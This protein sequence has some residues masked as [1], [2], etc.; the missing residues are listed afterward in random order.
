MK[1]KLLLWTGLTTSILFYTLAVFFQ[2]EIFEGFCELMALFE[3]YELDEIVLPLMI[4][5]FF[6]IIYLVQIRK[7]NEI[8]SKKSKIHLDRLKELASSKEILGA[9]LT[10]MSQLKA[11]AIQNSNLDPD[12]MLQFDKRFE[13]VEASTH[14]LALLQ[15]AEEREIKKIIKRV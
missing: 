9:L 4:L 6:L 11:T 1:S 8:D 15:E 3:A 10:N 5:N 13:E 2:L 7:E 14:K 12:W